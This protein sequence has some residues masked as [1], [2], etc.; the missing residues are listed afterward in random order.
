MRQ[1]DDRET[2]AAMDVLVPR[3]GEL[4]GGS[5]REERLDVLESR[6]R[7]M[8]QDP[9]NYWWYLD[10]RRFGSVWHG[11]RAPRHDAHRYFQYP[12]RA[13]VPPYAGLVGVLGGDDGMISG[14]G[15]GG[16][17]RKGS[18]SPLQN[19]PLSLPRLLA[20]GEAAWREFVPAE[21]GD[22]SVL[23]EKDVCRGVKMGTA[24]CS[25]KR[26]TLQC[27]CE[28]DSEA[29]FIPKESGVWPLLAKRPRR[30]PQSP[31]GVAVMPFTCRT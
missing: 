21:D 15:E 13:P 2:V 9:A 25:G 10:L 26:K 29:F 12:R 31:A 30:N 22:F 1:N 6:I 14:R 19:P 3:I 17:L 8:N 7:E 27:P 28:P 11:L 24:M 23:W 18:L 16:F 20:G 5:Q 4:I